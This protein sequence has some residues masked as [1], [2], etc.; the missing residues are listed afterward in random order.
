MG[1]YS[2]S[3]LILL[4][5]L[6]YGD[7]F[8]YEIIFDRIPSSAG[9]QSE[10]VNCVGQSDDGY[11]WVGTQSGLQRYDGYRMANFRRMSSSD[12][13][14]PRPVEQILASGMKDQIWVRT[15]ISIG[16]FNTRTFE[17]RNV[18]VQG[19][20]PTEMEVMR[21]AQGITYLLL[22]GQALL[23]YNRQKSVFE[24]S[25]SL[26]AVSSIAKPQT[27]HLLKNGSFY[28]G[29]AGGLGYYEQHTG[30]F[31]TAKNNPVGHALLKQTKGL[32]NIRLI[33]IDSKG[34][35]FLQTWPPD[36]GSKLLLF[37]Q[38][39][40]PLEIKSSPLNANAYYE[41]NNI[42]E[43]SG[44]IWAMG[45]GVF[46]IFEDVDNEFINF[47]DKRSAV[48][49]I[50]SNNMLQLFKDRDANLWL[51]TNDGLYMTSVVGDYIRNA[52]YPHAD[53]QGMSSVLEVSPKH[54]LTASWGGG[55]QAFS[56]DNRLAISFDSGFSEKIYSGA[57]GA[58]GAY[59]MVWDMALDGNKNIWLACQRGRLIRFNIK[60]NKSE[61]LKPVVFRQQ[62]IRS[63]VC[64]KELT[65]FGTQG[66]LLISLANGKWETLLDLKV[67]IS[68][69]HLDKQGI[70]WI[71][72]GGLG[73]IKYALRKY[74]ILNQFTV[75]NNP[76]GLSSNRITDVT[77]LG[78]SVLAIA[79]DVNLDLLYR[80]SGKVLNLSPYNI[81]N[82]NIISSVTSDA[83][84]Y[85]WMNSN[86]GILRY[87]V[88]KNRLRSYDQK[89]G[90][91]STSLQE[92]LMHLSKRFSDSVLFFAG[93]SNFILF[94]P[95]S[96]NRRFTPKTVSITGFR[97]FNDYIPLDEIIKNNT[98]KLKADQN[99]FSLYFSSLSY[100]Q[101]K[102]LKYFYS[103]EKGEDKWIQI[104]NGQSA[105]FNSVAPGKYTFK[106]YAVNQAEL[107]SPSVTTLLI[108]IEPK[109]YQT[110]WF[111]VL[112]IA[113]LALTVFT[114]YRLRL[115]RLMAVY[116]LREK[117][118][119]DLHDDMGSTLTTINILSVVAQRNLKEADK[120]AMEYLQKI[121]Q[122]SSEMMESM[123]DIVWSI[124]PDN[125]KLNK[126]LFR[127]REHTIQIL[128][129]QHINYEFN[130]A[131]D[132]S[133]LKLPMDVR[134]N[135]FLIYKEAL[136]N[137]SK[138]ASA[139]SVKIEIFTRNRTLYV[140]I[141]DDG[142]GF[143][144][145]ILTNG[146]GLMNMRKRAELMRGMLEVTSSIGHGT[147]IRLSVPIP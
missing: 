103:F 42:S 82:Q 30:K 125:D 8:A 36:G 11:L 112:I 33:F 83:R 45:L 140:A 147:S 100:K 133:N 129:M 136:N 63:V 57:P 78:D 109:F 48:Y 107:H 56:Y 85:L 26:D 18:A 122:N 62:T 143:D 52:S 92:N 39:H 76:S 12:E 84:G 81:L 106:I 130:A 72:T 137:I 114:I 121:G 67:P 68:K 32:R 37:Q 10:S 20:Q 1:T 111:M 28:I 16:L 17:Y 144:E 80:Q 141:A 116:N 40:K 128:E 71:G 49:G 47:Y 14:P 79:C 91:V 102:Q 101:S 23:I 146:N 108:D 5:I 4:L 34:R 69:L 65:L 46:N 50:P 29:G 126:I 113:I 123:D 120:T 93:N 115:S 19:Y 134:R 142:V 77:A 15:G 139:S 87:D 95:D 94:R 58:D 105:N 27:L 98:I 88:K 25:K 51:A 60:K 89:D 104:E 21:S 41:I 132:M 54:F 124:K 44:V 35:C 59:K 74:K 61:F 24:K 138:Y 2:K 70:L 13:I 135:L 9:L 22:K 3:Y 90:M 55:V 38:N 118:A 131:E 64:A 119:R 117:V 97:L 7:A 31:F 66:G 127:L 43:Q 86:G 73:L 99:V 75:E 96:L 110:T 145:R 53:T 6:V